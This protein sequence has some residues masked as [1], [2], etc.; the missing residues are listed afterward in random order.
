MSRFTQ[1]LC[2]ELRKILPKTDD[3]DPPLTYIIQ[4]W[5]M[6]DTEDVPISIVSILRRF[7]VFAFSLY[8]QL[9][10]IPCTL[11][12]FDQYWILCDFKVNASETLSYTSGW[13]TNVL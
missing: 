3:E 11:W 5:I 8:S 7:K 4:A 1:V 13:F 6:T 10:V 12:R 9:N 2:I